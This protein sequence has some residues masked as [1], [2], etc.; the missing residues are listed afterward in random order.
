MEDG[1]SQTLLRV[2]GYYCLLLAEILEKCG[3][4]VLLTYDK[5]PTSPN[6]TLF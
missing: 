5:N 1:W 4:A 3:G 2:V 6:N